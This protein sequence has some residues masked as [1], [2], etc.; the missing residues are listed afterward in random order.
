MDL[1]GQKNAWVTMNMSPLNIIEILMMWIK[2]I[3]NEILNLY[4]KKGGI[5]YESIFLEKYFLFLKNN[6]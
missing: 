1:L 2:K 4:K 3:Y 5:D 6:F